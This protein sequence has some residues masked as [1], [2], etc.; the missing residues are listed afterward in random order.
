MA[1]TL[2]SYEEVVSHWDDLILRAH[3]VE[4]GEQILYQEGSLTAM[5]RPDELIGAYL[6]EQGLTVDEGL[7]V[8]TVMFCGTL[9]AIDGIRPSGKFEMML[10]DPIKKV[11]MSQTYQV[12][13]LPTVA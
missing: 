7:P 4:N 2:W 11:T 12:S 3:I 13:M 10:E 8:G 9:P 6:E 1:E 5:R